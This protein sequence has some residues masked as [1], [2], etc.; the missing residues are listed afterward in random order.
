MFRSG[1]Y[2]ENV[3]FIFTSGICPLIHRIIAYIFSK[4][5]GIYPA[6]L[7][8][9]IYGIFAASV[10]WIPAID[11]EHP[12]G[13]FSAVKFIQIVDTFYISRIIGR[14]EAGFHLDTRFF[15]DTLQYIMH[16]FAFGKF[17]FRRCQNPA[18]GRNKLCLA[19]L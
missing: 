15:A 8:T 12:S 4:I 11:A 13:K 5:A 2:V 19:A 10:V 6:D 1:W 3:S 17:Y 14:C 16:R 9:C 7:I 18:I